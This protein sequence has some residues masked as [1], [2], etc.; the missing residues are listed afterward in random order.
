MRA[1]TN[2]QRG[3]TLVELLIVLALLGIILVKATMVMTATTDVVQRESSAMMIEDHA[4]VVLDRIALAI[5]ACDRD[6]LAPILT[7]SHSTEVSYTFSLGVEDGAVVWADPENIAL[8]GAAAN[9]VVW[10]Q[11]PD[12]PEERKVVWSNLVRPFL[13]GEVVNGVDDNG[14]GLVDEE[15]LTFYVEKN[16]VTIRLSIE[17]PGEEGQPAIQTVETTVTVRNNPDPV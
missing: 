2:S 9:Q 14:N 17:V 5:M 11:S 8:D 15:G 3:F 6:S 7:P 1:G 16:R 12:L 13:E 4:R 10:K